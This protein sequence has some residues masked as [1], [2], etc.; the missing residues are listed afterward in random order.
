MGGLPAFHCGQ[1]YFDFL[2][3][4]GSLRW[5]AKPS[6]NSFAHKKA[7]GRRSCSYSSVRL[8][9]FGCAQSVLVP[10]L[11]PICASIGPT[12]LDFAVHLVKKFKLNSSSCTPHL[13]EVG[14]HVPSITPMGTPAP[15]SILSSLLPCHLQNS[16]Y[17]QGTLPTPQALVKQVVGI[18]TGAMEA[19]GSPSL[20]FIL[21][22]VRGSSRTHPRD[23][24]RTLLK[25]PAMFPCVS[26]CLLL[27]QTHCCSIYPIPHPP[28][29]HHPTP[30]PESL[31]CPVPPFYPVTLLF[32]PSP[33]KGVGEL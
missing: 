14:S 22:S 25:P 23:E 9:A 17:L 15:S 12:Y 33:G 2:C 31:Y 18:P 1:G 11:K 24:S 32:C 16:L 19:P 8:L 21:I 29:H 5:F 6:I 27:L 13:R 4:R 3:D 20:F 10:L 28:T 30:P 26:S 7:R